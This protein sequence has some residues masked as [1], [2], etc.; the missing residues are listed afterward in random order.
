MLLRQ[1]LLV[2]RALNQNLLVVLIG[3]F[4][5]G[6]RLRCLPRRLRLR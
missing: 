5:E 2:K 4:A 6:V 1:E 3:A